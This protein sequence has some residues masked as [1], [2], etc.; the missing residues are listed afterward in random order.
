MFAP[1]AHAGCCMSWAG[2]GDHVALLFLFARQG[3][4]QRRSPSQRRQE[5]S[6]PAAA[7]F[8]ALLHGPR[9]QQG[10]RRNA[11]QAPEHVLFEPHHLGPHAVTV[12]G[13][14]LAE[15]WCGG[16]RGQCGGVGD[17]QGICPEG[18]GA[19][20][21]RDA[22]TQQRPGACALP[23]EPQRRLKARTALSVDLEAIGRVVGLLRAGLDRVAVHA[24]VK[25]AARVGCA[26]RA[27]QEPGRVVAQVRLAHVPA[28]RPART[29]TSGW[30]VSAGIGTEVRARGPVSTI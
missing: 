22:Q 24:L 25:R 13:V 28:A 21:V 20:A 17:P 1:P 29:A 30:Q 19:A 12:T 5:A 15:A 6:V 16:G 11:Q 2:P 27:A 23:G 3:A 4:Q 18:L 26:V 7:S 14:L 8:G 9:T 10:P